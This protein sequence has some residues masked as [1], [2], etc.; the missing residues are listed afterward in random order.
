ME[1]VNITD[2]KQNIGTYFDT[3]IA[4]PKK[5]IIIQRRKHF[6]LVISIDGLSN[7][8]LEQIRQIREKKTDYVHVGI[9]DK[10]RVNTLSKISGTK[11]K[12][13]VSW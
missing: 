3:L 10:D 5:P 1:V 12:K 7:T 9:Q 6:A 11:K 8:D 13:F 2:F 4:K